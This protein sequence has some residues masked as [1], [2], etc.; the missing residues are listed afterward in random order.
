MCERRGVEGW[1][2]VEH[3]GL[4]VQVLS[5]GYELEGVGYRRQDAGCRVSGVGCSKGSIVH[6]AGW[7]L[8]AI[9]RFEEEGR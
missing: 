2:R 9:A 6:G 8:Q 7:R 3:K 4:A 5:A 1:C